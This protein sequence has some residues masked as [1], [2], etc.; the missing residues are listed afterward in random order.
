MGLTRLVFC[1]EIKKRSMKIALST[2]FARMQHIDQYLSLLGKKSPTGY[3]LG[4]Q[5][6]HDYNKVPLNWKR[7]IEKKVKKVRLEMDTK[8]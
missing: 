1:F 8:L 5:E 6:Y 7:E 3:S 4:S 2:H